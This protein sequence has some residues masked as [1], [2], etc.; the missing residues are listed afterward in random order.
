MLKF[1][2]MAYNIIRSKFSIFII[3]Y[4]YN[5]KRMSKYFINEV[6][7]MKNPMKFVSIVLLTL[8]L[9]SCTSQ[10]KIE[11]TNKIMHEEMFSEIDIVE[12]PKRLIKFNIHNISDE[13]IEKSFYK[14]RIPK[15]YYDA[16]MYYTRNTPELRMPF[17]SI[18][19]HESANFRVYKRKNTNGS[20]DLGPS[21]LNSNNIKN[22]YF[23]ELYNPKDESHITNVYCF[24]MIM[25]LNYFRDMVD[26]FDGNMTDAY[27]AYNGGQKAPS[28][29]KSK[30][31][32][33]KRRNFVRNVTAYANA[34]NRN[35]DNFT[36]ELALYKQEVNDK[37]QSGIEYL[38]KNQFRYK[39]FT[40]VFIVFSEDNTL[41]MKL[42]YIPKLNS[43]TLTSLRLKL[44]DNP[45]Y[46][47]I[48]NSRREEDPSDLVEKEVKISFNPIIRI[49]YKYC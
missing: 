38:D 47:V 12:L 4:Y 32:P 13:E 37:I 15:E 20:Y 17:Y 39:E 46:Y 34:I 5:D 45:R 8:V 26:K 29:I 48:T 36:N 24:Y 40:D 21:H 28:I 30:N 23:R 27:C 49:L 25:S 19:V 3:I 33:A 1:Y 31:I 6:N 44:V 18:M 2:K 7:K 9:C 11:S 16:F 42:A 43:D 41:Q 22:P 35:V 10:I 14:D